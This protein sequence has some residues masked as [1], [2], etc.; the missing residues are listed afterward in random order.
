MLSTAP[1]ASQ[2]SVATNTR[3]NTA[4]YSGKACQPHSRLAAPVHY[5]ANHA[6]P[7]HMPPIAHQTLTATE[8]VSGNAALMVAPIDCTSTCSRFI[9]LSSVKSAASTCSAYAKP[10][11][12]EAAGWPQTCRL[13]CNPQLNLTEDRA[14]LE[15]ICWQLETVCTIVSAPRDAADKQQTHSNHHEAASMRYKLL[16]H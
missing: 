9:A 14:Q 11:W 4:T 8:S 1:Y 15:N 13:A 12:T 7:Q 16:R 5:T 2:T 3:H 10:S 6:P